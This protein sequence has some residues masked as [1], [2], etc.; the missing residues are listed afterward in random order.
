MT[1]VGLGMNSAATMGMG[2]AFMAG[3]SNFATGATS[4]SL[5]VG[6][7]IPMIG[8]IIAVG[9]L[10][11]NIF[12]DE[13]NPTFRIRYGQQGPNQAATPFGNL[14]FEGNYDAQGAAPILQVI[15]SFD[16]RLARIMSA[17]QRAGAGDRLAAYDAAGRRADGQP[18]Q[19]SFP[20]GSD[21]EAI[22]QIT[23]E[24]L[25]GRFGA[26]FAEIDTRAAAGIRDFRGDSAALQKYIESLIAMQ[27]VVVSAGGRLDWFTGLMVD[28]ASQG[29]QVQAAAGQMLGYLATDIN[30]LFDEAINAPKTAYES[31]FRLGDSIRGWT[32]LS[33]EGMVELGNLTQ[34]RYQAELALVQQIAAAIEQTDKMFGDTIRSITL[35]TLDTPGKYDFIKKETDSLMERIGV[36]ADPEMLMQMGQQLTSNIAELFNLLDPATQRAR[37]G[38]YTSYLED[39]RDVMQE[40]LAAARKQIEDERNAALSESVA[41]AIQ[42]AL[43]DFAAK[44][45]Q[46]SADLR[47]GANAINDAAKTFREVNA[48]PQ[49]IIIYSAAGGVLAEVNGGGG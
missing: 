47:T 23:V 29:E 36:T 13:E 3:A 46:A 35:Q 26:I 11:Y 33:A 15:G 48:T 4:M 7:M 14:G 24:L 25:K 1:G 17:D 20:D 5:A 27:E 16:S 39:A 28:F 41:T 19:F 9:V 37:L 12:K 8:A 6:Q 44:Q 30:K 10:L 22:E 31:W 45:S 32:D 2:N 38:E 42:T 40:K 49:K 34:Q 21:K 43:Q 18:A